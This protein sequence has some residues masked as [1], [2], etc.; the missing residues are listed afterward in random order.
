VNLREVPSFGLF[1]IPYS[2]AHSDGTLKKPKAT[3]QQQCTYHSSLHRG[4]G[5]S[6]DAKIGGALTFGDI[7]TA[8]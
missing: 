2:L 3:H 6:S 5:T 1:T 8:R 4:N 7:V